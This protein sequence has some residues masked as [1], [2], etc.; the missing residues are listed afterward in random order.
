MLFLMASAPAGQLPRSLLIQ[1]QKLKVD[2]EAAMLEIDQILKANELNMALLAAVPAIIIT[3]G[4]LV[5]T[6]RYFQ[7][8][9][10]DPKREALPCRMA[11][12]EL[13][14]AIQKLDGGCAE[15][16]GIVLFELWKVRRP[17]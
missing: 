10:P 4:V 17:N 9:P 13:E 14:R 12:V 1:V 11:M 2:T 8:T 7:P 5:L 16:E 3:G 15:D 6:Y